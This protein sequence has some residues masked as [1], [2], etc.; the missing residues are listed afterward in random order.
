[1]DNLLVG[2]SAYTVTAENLS[3]I[4]DTLMANAAV[5]VPWG[6][7][8]VAIVAGIKFVPRLIKMFARG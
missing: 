2:A 8:I 1:M 6:I 5:I 3:G 7:G 4:T